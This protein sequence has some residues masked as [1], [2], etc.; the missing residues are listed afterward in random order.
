MESPGR[1][2]QVFKKRTDLPTAVVLFQMNAL[3]MQTIKFT[4]HSMVSAIMGGLGKNGTGTT[5]MK[6]GTQRHLWISEMEKCK[7]PMAGVFVMG[8]FL[9]V[10]GDCRNWED[11]LGLRGFMSWGNAK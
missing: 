2:N 8:Y 9:E 5:S 4:N 7:K 6:A 11:R 3:N 1:P 10:C